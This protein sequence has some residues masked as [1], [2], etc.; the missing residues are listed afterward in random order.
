KLVAVNADPAGGSEAAYAQTRNPMQF[1]GT[2]SCGKAITPIQSNAAMGMNFKGS[3]T[4]GLVVSSYALPGGT[5]SLQLAVAGNFP[6]QLSDTGEIKLSAAST[7]VTATGVAENT[8]K[9]RL[10]FFLNED[11]GPN[12]SN[13]SLSSTTDLLLRRLNLAGLQPKIDHA[14]IPADL[15]LAGT[16]GPAPAN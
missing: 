15:V 13:V 10:Q 2:I 3:T 8:V 1:Q 11:I 16:L 7:S 4:D 12:I 5:I 14:Q 6:L 9:P